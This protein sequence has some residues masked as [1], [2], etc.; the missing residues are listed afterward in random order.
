MVS[1]GASVVERGFETMF[2]QDKFTKTFGAT[3]EAGE[4]I[5][6]VSLSAEVTVPK[7]DTANDSDITSSFSLGSMDII[8]PLLVDFPISPSFIIQNIVKKGE[9]LIAIGSCS[10]TSAYPDLNNAGEFIDVPS[11]SLEFRIN[12]RTSITSTC[13][14]L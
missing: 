14:R 9:Q 5:K 1:D 3:I 8:F 6:R 12:A 4:E 10:E 11:A 13:G 2:G 7:A